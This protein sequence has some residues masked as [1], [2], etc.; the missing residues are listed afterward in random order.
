MSAV[1]KVYE[2]VKE[3]RSEKNRK[4]WEQMHPD[5]EELQQAMLQQAIRESKEELHY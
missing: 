5:Y 4:K 3:E 1:L 2:K